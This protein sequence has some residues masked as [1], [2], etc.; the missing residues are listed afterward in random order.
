MK[1]LFTVIIILL[2]PI[3]IYGVEWT[4]EYDMQQTD[5]SVKETK[6][7]IPNNQFL[8]EIPYLAGIWRCQTTRLDDEPPISTLF[9][10]R[11]FLKR[12]DV[13][14]MSAKQ[15]EDVSVMYDMR[16]TDI[17]KVKFPEIY[18]DTPENRLVVH[19]YETETKSATIIIECKL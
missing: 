19:L 16:C 7:L 10:M 12:K 15:V 14:I 18:T 4:V 8:W 5:G 1:S 2:L 11:C 9:R 6:I 3:S 17:Q 13:I